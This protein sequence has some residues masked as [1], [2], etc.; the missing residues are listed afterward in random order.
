MFIYFFLA[1][2]SYIRPLYE[3]VLA[4]NNAV[5]EKPKE[6]ENYL[7]PFKYDTYYRSR[8]KKKYIHVSIF[9]ILFFP[10]LLGQRTQS[11]LS[12]YLLYLDY[13]LI[14]SALPLST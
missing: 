3:L 13:P 11:F 10:G 4:M 2:T 7:L 5:K 8:N 14:G 6:N 9:A 12:F 1:Q